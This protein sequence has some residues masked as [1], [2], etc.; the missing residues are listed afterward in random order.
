MPIASLIG[1]VADAAAAEEDAVL[2]VGFMQGIDKLNPYTGLNDASYI[3]YGLVYDALHTVDQDLVTKA[4]LLEDA[5]PVPEDDPEL[6]A[7]GSPYGSIWEY[8]IRQ[9]VYWHDGEPFTG[10]D[11]EWN[12]NLNCDKDNYMNMWAYQPY[13]YF[14]EYAELSPTDDSVVRV[15]FYDRATLEPIPAA[16][17]SL[18]CMPMVPKHLLE[19]KAASYIGFDWNGVFENYTYPIVGTGPFTGT[20]DILREWRDESYMT[21]VKNERYFGLHGDATKQVKF[22]KI[23]MRFYTEMT[24]MVDALVTGLLDIAQFPPQAYDGLKEDVENGDVDNIACYDGLRCTQYWT[25]IGINF[26]IEGSP[27]PSRCDLNVRKALAMATN[28]QYIVDQFYVGYADVGTTLISPVS[29]DWHYEPTADEVIPFD[30]EDANALLEANGYRY[31]VENPVVG[32]D[33][34]YAT[35]DSYA[36]QQGW[37]T[38]NTKMTYNMMVRGQE[39]P[40]ELDIAIQLQTDWKEI[41]VELIIDS[42]PE[43]QLSNLAYKYTYDMLIWYWSADVDPNYMLFCQAQASWD[44]WSDNMYVNASYEE[45]YSGAVQEFDFDKRQEYVYNCQKVHYED[46]GYII[47]AYVYQTYAWRT[48]TFTGW[49][50]WTAHPGLSFDHFWTAPPLV[51]ELEYAGGIETEGV[52][53]WVIGAVVAGIVAVVAGVFLM[54]RMGKGKKGEGESPLGD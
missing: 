11:L 3:F 18:I 38:P 24:S 41:G 25:E 40:E 20:D 47:L 2:R 49:G 35:S 30:L 43:D 7:S 51:F 34:R 53:L 17:A 29:E 23:I 10:E 31:L 39:Y 37:V 48:D 13:A 28:K 14:M 52:P 19:D 21:L 6:V 16:Y 15:Y 22:D 32:Q 50:D 12:I 44:G 33:Y 27:N 8:V 9:N 36:V 54:K 45:N 4:N 46:V 42:M 1:V 5:Y 26:N